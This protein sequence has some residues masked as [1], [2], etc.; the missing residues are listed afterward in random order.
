MKGYC[1][2]FNIMFFV[3]FFFGLFG[4]EKN[5]WAATYYIA[6]DG[7][8][9]NEGTSKSTPWLHGPGMYGCSGNCLNKANGTSGYSQPTGGDSFI[10]KGGDTWD[11]HTPTGAGEPMDWWDFWW[12]GTTGSPIYIG[13]DKAWYTGDTWTRPKLNGMN[14]LSTSGVDSC[15]YHSGY[16]SRFLSPGGNY[17][18]FDNIEFLGMCWKVFDFYSVDGTDRLSGDGSFT[19]GTTNWTLGTGWAYG[20]N[21]VVKNTAG[22]GTLSHNTFSALGANAYRLSYTISNLSAGSVTPTVGGSPGTTRSADGTYME[23]IVAGNTDGIIFTST[24]PSRFTLDDIAVYHLYPTYP[25]YMSTG[26]SHNV[27]QNLYFH[28]WTHE[29]FVGHGGNNGDGGTALFGDTHK[30]CCPGNQ[31]LYNVCDGADSDE[32]SF[33]CQWGDGY[34][35]A[36]STFRNVGNGVI[37]GYFHLFHHNL[38]ENIYFSDGPGAHSNGFEFNNEAAGDN[39][40]YNNIIRNFQDSSAIVKVWLCPNSITYFYNNVMYGVGASGNTFDISGNYGPCDNVAGVVNAY[41]NTWVGVGATIGTSPRVNFVNNHFIDSSLGGTAL[42]N[43]SYVSQTTS[44]ATADGY[45]SAN[46]YAPTQRTGATV[47]AGT[48]LSGYFTTDI[49]GVSRPR[50]PA[51]DIGAYEYVQGPDTTVP[52]PPIG[53]SVQ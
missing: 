29:K 22:T 40:V 19:G 25:A 11:T 53:L 50:G 26:Y 18:I 3:I 14:P 24:S 42:Q 33:I 20:T 43:T 44:Q 39:F 21:N 9:S 7:F 36:Y 10:L 35:T 48:N 17:L 38:F 45:T 37:G 51:W 12:S 13:V 41:N 16:R 34:E 1:P 52:T 31:Y 6:A 47:D 4:L 49:L 15:T 27:Y 46:N 23:D 28:G 30:D 5:A 8:D 32:H 2:N